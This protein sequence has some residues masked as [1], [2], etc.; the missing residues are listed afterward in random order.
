V[1][2]TT[3]DARSA[4][5]DVTLSP[6]ATQEVEVP[7][8]PLATATGRIV[9]AVT[10][11]P[12]ADVALLADQGVFRTRQDVS[13]AD[14]RFQIQVSGGEHNLRGFLRGYQALSSAFTAE[15]GRPV[16][17]GD[18]PMRPLTTSP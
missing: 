2:V 15:A 10:H 16:E 5:V 6:G 4:A 8:Q 11:Q 13:G 18:L 12:L 9:D 1:V 3:S 17:L 14:G 7:L